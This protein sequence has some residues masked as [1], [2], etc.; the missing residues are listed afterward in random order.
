MPT[1]LPHTDRFKRPPRPRAWTYIVYVMRRSIWRGERADR[2]KL[3][4][5]QKS[6]LRFVTHYIFHVARCGIGNAQSSAFSQ[7]HRSWMPAPGLFWFRF[8]KQ[9]AWATSTLDS[10]PHFQK[11]NPSKLSCWRRYFWQR[12]RALG[13]SRYQDSRMGVPSLQ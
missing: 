8:I 3:Q 2:R 10:Y 9:E 11:S 5:P 1:T 6:I 7:M 12:S 4:V 13:R